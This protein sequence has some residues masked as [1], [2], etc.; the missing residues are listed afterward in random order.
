MNYNAVNICE[1]LESSQM[2]F[3]N[4][5]LVLLEYEGSSVFI[6]PKLSD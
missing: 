4:Q 5:F 3:H 1:Y 6:Q 2:N